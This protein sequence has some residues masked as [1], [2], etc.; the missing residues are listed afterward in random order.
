MRE[1]VCVPL[2]Q[3]DARYVYFLLFQTSFTDFVF[4]HIVYRAAW[5]H[6]LAQ[7]VRYLRAINLKPSFAKPPRAVSVG[8][9]IALPHLVNVEV[10]AWEPYVPKRHKALVVLNHMAKKVQPH[11]ITNLVNLRLDK[12]AAA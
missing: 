5:A 8:W 9:R 7:P 3:H 1:L 6:R 10:R 12:R 2:K 11:A 4:K